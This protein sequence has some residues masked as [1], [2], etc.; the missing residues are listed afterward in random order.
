M[1]LNNVKYY[2]EIIRAGSFS[3]ASQRLNIPLATLSCRINDLEKQLGKQLLQRHK[4]GIKPTIEG[5]IFY[6]QTY[7]SIENLQQV[8]HQLNTTEEIKAQINLSLPPAFTPVLDWINRFQQQF[9]HIQFH[10]HFSEQLSDPL[11]THTDIAIRIG[12][13]HTDALIAKKIM[14]IKGLLVATPQFLQ[15]YGKPLTLEDLM[16]FPCATWSSLSIAEPMWEFNEKSIY[17]NYCI[18]TNDNQA[19]CYLV[20]KDKVIALL[21][22]YL[23]AN[24]IAEGTLIELFPQQARPSYP[25]HLLYARRRFPSPAIKAFVDFCLNINN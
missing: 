20:E 11:M 2:I 21:P 18:S 23:V 14:E 22:N 13:L 15:K 4:N 8:E 5:E 6:Q 16:R 19:L 9:P 1:D 10:C 25:V 24:K 12:K 17:P 3:A 7:E